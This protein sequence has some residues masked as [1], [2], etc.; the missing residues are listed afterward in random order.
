MIG[1]R[2][3]SSA[4]VG[5]R[6]RSR[7]RAWMRDAVYYGWE[8][9]TTESETETRGNRPH[10]R[11]QSRER[12][13]G[14]RDARGREDGGGGD[15][16]DDDGAGK[17]GVGGD[18]AR[19][20]VTT[21]TTTTVTPMRANGGV[22]PPPTAPRLATARTYETRPAEGT[23]VDG[24]GG[25]AA[26][27]TTPNGTFTFVTPSMMLFGGDRGEASREALERELAREFGEPTSELPADVETLVYARQF[28][29]VVRLFAVVDMVFCVL[30]ALVGSG[31]TALMIVG[32]LC[33]FVGARTYSPRGVAAYVVFCT[34][35]IVW[36]GVG[37]IYAN[38]V[39]ARVL[40]LI[41]ILLSMYVTRLVGKFY[42]ILAS[43]PREGQILLR[44]LDWASEM[45]R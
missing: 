3:H 13:E 7:D 20:A 9:E 26:T 23:P 27:I 43:I 14:S 31:L 41:S 37:F 33:G 32:P 30:H 40:T 2:A 12:V 35:N 19:R 18:D 15:G 21:T 29:R 36:K 42:A 22:A 5:E 24:R 39:T 45:L 17:P 8:G 44:Q 25:G 28:S 16:G 6:A 1:A 11:H 4:R 10:H 38:D 34:L